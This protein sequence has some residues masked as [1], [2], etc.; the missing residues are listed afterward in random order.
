MA[1]G[2]NSFLRLKHHG[3][4]KV[5]RQK[6][7]SPKVQDLGM[8]WKIVYWDYSSGK[9]RKRSKVWSKS[10]VPTLKKVQL[11]ADEFMFEVNSRNNDPRLASP[12]DYTVAGLYKKCSTLLWP[13][14][15]KPSR[16]SYE[17][18][19][20]DYIVPALG[21]V[22]LDEL[23]LMQ[24]QEFFSSVTGLSSKSV[25]NMHAAL[26]AALSEAVRWGLID[27][28]PA[29]GV[30]LKR[31]RPVKPPVILLFEDIRRVIEALPEPAKS[32]VLLIVLASMRVGEVLALRWNDVLEGCIVVDERIWEGDLDDPKTLRGKRELPYDRQGILAAVFDRAWKRSKHRKPD[33]FAFSTRNGTALERRNVLRHLKAVAKE[34]GLPKEIDFRSFRTM[35]AS[36][37]RHAGARAEV[38]RDSMGHSE[39]PT[40]LEI[41]SKSWWS[42]RQA[43]VSATVDLLLSGDQKQAHHTEARAMRFAQAPQASIGAPTGAPALKAV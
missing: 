17:Y 4:D 6:Y 5:V 37:M 18:Y 41:Y 35:H 27:R 12:D 10:Y 34:L 15:K 20:A 14:L 1:S 36:L 19:F 21:N 16:E 7:Q 23:S 39:V 33:D 24:L 31:V 38:V 9:A 11:L 3:K 22:R 29:V 32:V 8:K 13:L 30:K 40:T 2:A 42:E 28:N 25:K 26:R 43:A